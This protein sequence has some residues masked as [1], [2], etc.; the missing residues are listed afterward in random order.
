[1][2]NA[3][4]NGV[5]DRL[6]VF[7]GDALGDSAL[8]KRIG[9]RRYP[10]I[11]LNIVADVIIALAQDAA[12]WL[13]PGGSLVCSGIIQGREEEVRAALEGA[14]LR[15]TAHRQMENWHSYTLTGG[16]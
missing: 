2:A 1:M 3:A 9:V 6:T 16:D 8:R 10:L 15:V 13:E 12:G 7:A 14:G 4:L 11:F 5:E